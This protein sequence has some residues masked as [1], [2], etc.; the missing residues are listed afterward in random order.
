MPMHFGHKAHLL[1]GVPMRRERSGKAMQRDLDARKAIAEET[2]DDPAL[3]ETVRRLRRD[4]HS[5]EAIHRAM[6]ASRS[7]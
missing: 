3:A 6:L 4:G 5:P 7:R 1:H 2:R